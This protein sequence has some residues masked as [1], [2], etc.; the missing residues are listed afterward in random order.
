MT[1]LFVVLA[2]GTEETNCWSAMANKI[3]LP[4]VVVLYLIYIDLLVNDY[5]LV[6]GFLSVGNDRHVLRFNSK[7]STGSVSPLFDFTD[8]NVHL[9]PPWCLSLSV[10]FDGTSPI[11]CII[12]LWVIYIL[13]ICTHITMCRL[14]SALTVKQINAQAF[15]FLWRLIWKVHP[16][17]HCTWH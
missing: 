3:L 8:R 9:P 17:L 1:P 12:H 6:L 7:S 10:A 14:H 4:R 11:G 15:Y 13:Y 16:R 5:K 2:L